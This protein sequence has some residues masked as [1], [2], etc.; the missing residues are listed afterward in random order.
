MECFNRH[1]ISECHREAI[2]KARA[3]TGASIIDRLQV[4]LDVETEE[5]LLK[6]CR[7]F[8]IC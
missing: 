7:A 1:S 8:A 3:L 4:N 2:S 6:F 5:C